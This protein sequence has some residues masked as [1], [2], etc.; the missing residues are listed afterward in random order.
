MGKFFK[1]IG[2]NFAGRGDRTEFWVGFAIQVVVVTVLI[3]AKSLLG[4][5]VSWSGL[6]I[7][8][9]WLFYSC[10][11]F[12]DLGLPGLLGLLPFG[13]AF[14]LGVGA[15]IFQPD[16]VTKLVIVETGSLVVALGL[17][18]WL[19]CTRGQPEANA[20]GPPPGEE[21]PTDVF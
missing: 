4:F 12:H 20:Y 19:G 7:L 9:L 2:D 5:S 1:L 6:L 16:S 18:L 8:P 15:L 13:A 14:V 17:V 21:D 3:L 10:R 11:R